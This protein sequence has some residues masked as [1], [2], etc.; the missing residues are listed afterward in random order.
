MS[1][2]ENRINSA[3]RMVRLSKEFDDC[4]ENFSNNI[5]SDL[6]M[7]EIASVVL[8]KLYEWNEK[9]RKENI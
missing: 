5:D 8:K 6:T 4:I 1:K 3:S 2:F 9:E 7:N